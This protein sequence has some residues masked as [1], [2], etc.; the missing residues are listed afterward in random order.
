M[1]R[2]RE[3]KANRDKERA[4][5]VCFFQTHTHTP[6]DMH[7]LLM[8]IRHGVSLTP[9]YVWNHCSIYNITFS[10]ELCF[11]GIFAWDKSKFLV[12]TMSF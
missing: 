4:N 5:G 10:K 9:P 3:K 11:S 6:Y 7:S 2:E 12:A 1:R 8:H